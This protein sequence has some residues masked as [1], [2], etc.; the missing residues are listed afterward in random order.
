MKTSDGDSIEVYRLTTAY[1]EICYYGHESTAR[2]ASRGMGD[3]EKIRIP[4][5]QF[6]V[7][8]SSEH[9]K[10]KSEYARVYDDLNGTPCAQIKSLEDLGEPALYALTKNG[11]ID[12][13]SDYPFSNEPFYPQFDNEGCLPLYPQHVFFKM[14]RT[15]NSLQQKLLNYTHQPDP[16]GDALNSG[17]GVYRP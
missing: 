13:E 5:R 1:G 3:V 8:D 16:L 4:R 10:L 15:I 9:Q 6:S 2:A 7:V 17:C 11:E 12:W 14:L